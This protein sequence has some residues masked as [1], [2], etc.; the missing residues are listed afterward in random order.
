[1]LGIRFIKFP[2]TTYV[3]RYANGRVVREG[4]GLSFFY[5]SPTSSLVA[6]PVASMEAP[7]IFNEVTADFQ[8]VTIQGQVSYRI[9]DAKKIASLLNFTLDPTGKRYVSD[10]SE[11]LPSRV[12]KTVQVLTRKRVQH[13][14]LRQALRASEELVKEVGHELQESKEIVSLGL[15]I[16]GLSIL[17]IRPNPETARALEAE[18]KEQLLKEA[19]NAVYARRNSA[20]EQERAIKESEL[21]T[22]IAVENKKRQI[23]EA[24]MDAEH[25]VQQKQHELREAEMAS[26]ISL[27]Q[28][29]KDFVILA[30]ENA[31]READARAYSV[32]T[33]MRSIDKVDPKVLQ[34]LASMGM[35]PDQLIALAFQEMAE[36][37]DKI[38]QLN[39]SPDLLRELLGKSSK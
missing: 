38:G 27:E 15:E 17:A 11:K 2:P 16:L 1:M 32:S 3:L 10:D 26:K 31:K 24:Q 18:V 23:R 37:A 19:D 13:L 22:E 8:E 6:I 20:V 28:K 36:R 33:V 14:A 29:N 39:V 35:K 34:A 7:F 25:A 12:I 30:V 21:N 9:T 5:Y 4:A